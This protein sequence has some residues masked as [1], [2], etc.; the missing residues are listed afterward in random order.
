[1]S[2]VSN[3]SER[4]AATRIAWSSLPCFLS[5]L[6]ILCPLGVLLAALLHTVR[7]VPMFDDY[8]AILQFGLT[9]SS[10]RVSCPRWV[11][12]SSHRQATTN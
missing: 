5:V 7:Y 12:R 6:A 2:L 9:C 11:L 10:S 8:P 4:Q 3:E 1:M